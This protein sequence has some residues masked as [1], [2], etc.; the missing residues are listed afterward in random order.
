MRLVSVVGTR[1][2]LIKAAALLARPSGRGMTSVFV[3]TGQH[4]D[5][6]M[7]GD[8]LRASSACRSRTTRSGSAAAR[9]AEQTARMLGRS[10][11]SSI[12]E[13]PDAVARLRRHELDA[14]RGARGGQ[15]GH[16]GGPRRGRPAQLR[17]ADARGDEPGRRRP[18]L[19]AGCSRRRRPRSRTSRAEGIADGVD[20]RRRPHA[21]PRGARRPAR[22]GTRRA[23][24]RPSRAALGRALC[25]AGGYLFATV[26][27]AENREPDAMRAWTAIL[28]AA[29][30]A[31]PVVLA[32]HPGTAA[33]RSRTPASAMPPR[34]PRRRAPAATARRSR[35]SC[36]RPPC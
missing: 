17:P 10:S 27:R 26:H 3:D 5:E 6:P 33:S 18:P 34:R 4:W 8:V 15:A 21:G 30:P 31:R 12:A 7:A 2:Q 35:C 11:R 29:A 28:G 24:A 22:S 14:G 19:D 13:R 36:T 23:P 20:P 25:S 16:P 32:L 1:P 9:Q